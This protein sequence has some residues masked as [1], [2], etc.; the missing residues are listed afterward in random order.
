MQLVPGVH[1]PIEESAVA[2]SEFVVDVQIPDLPAVGDFREIAVDA[3]N[4][5]HEAHVVVSWEERRHNDRRRRR[6]GLEKTHNRLDAS[7][8][9]LCPRFGIAMHRR[10]TD[11]ICAGEQNDDFG[12]HS[13][14]F[15]VLQPPENILCLIGAPSEISRVPTEEILFPIGQQLRIVG[16]APAPRNRVALEIDVGRLA[17]PSRATG[18]GL[19]KSLDPSGIPPDRPGVAKRPRDSPG[20]CRPTE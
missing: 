19:P 4:N 20:T 6:L 13:V 17:W 14:E 10:I 1:H 2:I 7:R 3:V 18:N 12:I 16:G 5:G 15:A 9:I 8:D 11:V